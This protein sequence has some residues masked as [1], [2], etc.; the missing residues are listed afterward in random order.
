M[1]FLQDL[2]TLFVLL[3]VALPWWG[4]LVLGLLAPWILSGLLV[5]ALCLIPYA[6]IR[7]LVRGTT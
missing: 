7:R 1:S 4:V 6:V 3:M 2:L 5:V